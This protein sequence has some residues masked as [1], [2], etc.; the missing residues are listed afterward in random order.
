M[1]PDR[2]CAMRFAEFMDESRSPKFSSVG[3]PKP[4]SDDA[5]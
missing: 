4:S 1:F 2:P 3:Q 5:P